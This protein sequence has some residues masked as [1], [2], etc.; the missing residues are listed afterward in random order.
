MPK[1]ADIPV[2][3]YQAFWT[4]TCNKLKSEFQQ[5]IGQF[6]DADAQLKQLFKVIRHIEKMA[7]Y[8]PASVGESEQWS[9][10]VST[11]EENLKNFC[12]FLNGN[13]LFNALHGTY[14][15]ALHEL[16]A[17]LKASTP[18]GQ[19][20][21]P[22]SAATQEDGFKEVRR[23][24]RHN[25]NESAPTSKK[26]AFSAV[27]TPPKE[28]A[29]RNFFAPLRTSDMDTDSTNTEATP[30]EAATPAKPGRPP[31]MVL[32]SAVNLILLQK[33]LKGVVSENFEFRSK[34]NG[35]RVMTRNLADFQRIKSHFD[36]QNLSYYSFPK[37]EK[38]IKAV[39]RHLPHNT[40]AEDISESLVSL[41]FEDFSV[42]QMTAIRRSPPE[43]YKII[44]LPCSS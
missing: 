25:T 31:P 1:M 35:T 9:S 32:T 12:K 6:S 14:T 19:F 15:V 29:T 24:K 8:T 41:G 39:I 10:I 16:K 7:R 36:S 38:P 4:D 18:A 43:E 11:E 30:R 17:V 20:K 21:T 13:K 34:R 40:P 5:L 28:V 26:A 22:K 37:F 23:R 42:K 27:D 33:Q 44:N 2:P 3:G